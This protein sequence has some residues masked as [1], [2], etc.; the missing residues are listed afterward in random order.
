MQGVYY[1]FVLNVNICQQT[2]CKCVYTAG[3]LGFS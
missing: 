2:L 1:Y 3:A